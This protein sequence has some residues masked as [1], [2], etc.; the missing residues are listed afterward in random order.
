MLISR[1][2][3]CSSSDKYADFQDCH[4]QLNQSEWNF[5]YRWLPRNKITQLTTHRWPEILNFH[6]LG[7][8]ASL[9]LTGTT[10]DLTGAYIALAG[11]VIGACVGFWVYKD[12]KSKGLYDAG[13][14]WWL[15]V[16]CV[17]IFLPLYLLWG[18]RQHAWT[19]C[20]CPE[21]RKVT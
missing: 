4:E 11:L 12:A 15:T 8:M 7:S 6:S 16:F 18:R 10:L 1:R 20:A 17:T 9:D 5:R 3:G 2:Q 13:G 21:C 19:S 14:W